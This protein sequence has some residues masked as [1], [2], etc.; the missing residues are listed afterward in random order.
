MKQFVIDY[1]WIPVGFIFGLIIYGI[2]IISIIS[3]G[4][5]LIPAI[6]IHKLLKKYLKPHLYKLF[7]V[8]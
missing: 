6:L 1:W 7:G 3:L 4:L 8:D 5:A 2:S